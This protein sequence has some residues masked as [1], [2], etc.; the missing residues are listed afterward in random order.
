MLLAGDKTIVK[1]KELNSRGRRG[2]R[3][4]GVG[5]ERRE[6]EHREQQE[7]WKVSEW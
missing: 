7:R 6:S 3:G 1:E 4:E 2:G 5:L